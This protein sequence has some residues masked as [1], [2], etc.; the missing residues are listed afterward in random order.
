MARTV[1][2]TTHRTA[3]SRKR[4]TVLSLLHVSTSTRSSSGRYI[5]SLMFAKGRGKVHPR[6]GLEGPEVG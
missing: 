6:T 4:L 5:Q 2:N 1:F 3:N